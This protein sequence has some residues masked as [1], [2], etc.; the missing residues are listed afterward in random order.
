MI[1]PARVSLA[2]LAA[3]LACWLGG[4]A[5]TE[6][7]PNV[8]V[9]TLDT[10]RLDRLGIYGA[11]R[12][13]ITPRLDAFAEQCVVF[14]NAFANSSFT[15]P[16]HA[17]IFTSLYPAEHGLMWW[18]RKLADVPTAA[19]MFLAAGY[20]TLAFTPLRTL[21]AL[22]LDRGFKQALDVPLKSR[23]P[24]VLADADAINAEA[25]PALTARDGR[26]FFAWLHYYDAHRPYGRQGPEWSGRFTDDD[27]PSI[28]ADESWYQLTPER[29][30]ALGLSERQAQLVKDHYDGGLAYLDDRLGQM[31]DALERAG[32]LENT[33]VVL[34]ADHGEVLDEH[35]EEW[36]AH[37]PY[38]VDENIHIPFLVRLPG[39]KH[40][41]L[42]VSGL[43]S[44][45]DVLPTLLDLAGVAALPG[46]MSGRS[47]RPLIEGRASDVRW[48]YADR[49]GDDRDGRAPDR[50]YSV[51]GTI[52]KLVLY[53]DGKTAQ[54]RAV[55]GTSPES[56]DL[57]GRE[58]EADRQREITNA[59]GRW[60]AS[61]SDAGAAA[62]AEISPEML[63]MLEE[64]GYIDGNKPARNG[65]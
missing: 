3:C 27:D 26:P 44:Q 38:L 2:V 48:V 21:F 35:V 65:R 32:V 58:Q 17:S 6:P 62:G 49:M 36:F 22:G 59:L 37:D 5:D 40:A 55:D 39:A 28:G 61:L 11:A 33:I 18:N 19:E 30:A 57:F 34:I 16:T 15:P 31:L 14:D 64:I 46:R 29:R 52:R 1:S 45:V 54:L 7:P 53:A 47:L 23:E 43:V 9:I 51:R 63:E 56:E 10:V 8:L 13:G 41:G 50:R 24:V 4:C 12:P 25:I 20:R 42:R 60:Q